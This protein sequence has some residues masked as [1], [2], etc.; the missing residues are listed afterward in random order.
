MGRH[1]LVDSLYSGTDYIDFLPS[2]SRIGSFEPV[3]A[4]GVTREA[5]ESLNDRRHPSVGI[6]CLRMEDIP[7]VKATIPL[8]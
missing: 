5:R 6:K 7:K 2:W 3:T 8:T 1:V 4:K